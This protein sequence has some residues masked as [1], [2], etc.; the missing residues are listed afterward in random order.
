MDKSKYEA[1]EKLLAKIRANTASVEDYEIYR[2]ML[3]ENGLSEEYVVGVLRRNGYSSLYDFIEQRKAAQMY[4]QKS[5]TEGNA[6]GSLLGMGNGLLMYWRVE[7]GSQKSRTNA[8]AQ[9]RT[10]AA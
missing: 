6:L 8:Q 3:I 10:V 9:Q 4:H 5:S 2:A 7:S 1:L